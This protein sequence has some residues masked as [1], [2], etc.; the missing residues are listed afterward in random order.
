MFFASSF[1]Q[2]SNTESSETREMTR[3]CPSQEK[4]QAE[5]DRFQNSTAHVYQNFYS[6]LLFLVWQSQPHLV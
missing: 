5:G 4:A 1:G 2:L 6:P 3:V